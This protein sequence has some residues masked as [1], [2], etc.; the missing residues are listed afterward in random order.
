MTHQAIP[1]P[2]G[3]RTKVDLLSDAVAR[4]LR[5][6][7][8]QFG[9]PHLAWRSNQFS[10]PGLRYALVKLR[11]LH[12]ILR[13]VFVMLATHLEVTPT[14][15]CARLRLSTPV[16]RRAVLPDD[17]SSWA[18]TFTVVTRPRR[19]FVD[20]GPKQQPPCSG[21]TRDPLRTL[22]RRMEGLRRALADPMRHV[23][24]LARLLRRDVVYIAGRPPKRPPPVA[25]RDHWEEFLESREGASCAL[26]RRDTS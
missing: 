14:P 11:R 15:V 18:M 23:R 24:R 5:A 7:I 8:S 12:R 4:G 26:Q 16:S 6:L 25:W 2:P 20:D 13:Y 10:L 17:P 3:V 22:A 21:A 1:L 19:A 9:P